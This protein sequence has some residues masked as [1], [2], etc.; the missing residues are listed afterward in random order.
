VTIIRWL[1]RVATWLFGG[2]PSLPPLA[3]QIR[4]TLVLSKSRLPG[5]I[6]K[7]FERE[8]AQGLGE[9]DT[10]R[11]SFENTTVGM[12]DDDRELLSEVCRRESK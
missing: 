2:A 10:V 3:P 4:P 12:D 1:R 6:T 7:M 8:L 5:P 11:V 9:E